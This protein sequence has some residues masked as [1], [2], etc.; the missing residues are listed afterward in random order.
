MVLSHRYSTGAILVPTLATI[1]QKLHWNSFKIPLNQVLFWGR[2]E[3]GTF[4]ALSPLLCRVGI[5]KKLFFGSVVR[6]LQFPSLLLLF[7]FPNNFYEIG[8]QRAFGP[9]NYK[10]IYEW[11]WICIK[12]KLCTSKFHTRSTESWKSWKL[13][14][15]PLDI[16]SEVLNFQFPRKF[17]C[18][19]WVPN[20]WLKIFINQLN[21]WKMFKT[22]CIL[23]GN[24]TMF[25]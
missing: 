21:F 19:W 25:G 24:W 18:L 23:T 9:M 22:V 8:F 1:V 17:F 2:S 12:I 15:E 5:T 13:D 20:K 6:C 16:E 7:W 11:R 3:N 4:E 14:W 10:Q